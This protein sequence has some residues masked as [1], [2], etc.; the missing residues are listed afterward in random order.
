MPELPEVQTVLN[1]ITPHV[2]HQK[3]KRI[4]LHFPKLRWPIPQEITTIL[5]NEKILELSRRG[6][7]ILIHFTK[8]TLL[9]HLGMS[10]RLCVVDAATPLK[11]HDHVDIILSNNRCLRFTDPRRFG[12][13]LWT[14]DDINEHPLIKII[15]PEPLEDSFNGTYLWEKSRKKSVAVKTFI[16]NSKIVAG[17]GN[18]YA[19]EALFQAKIHPKKT[20]GKLTRE[21]CNRLSTS[22]K[23]VLKSAIKKGGTTL[24]DFVSADGNPGYFS[25]ELKVYGR[26]N[27][28]CVRCKTLLK[29]TRQ[30]NRSTVFC[31]RCQKL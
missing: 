4:D 5:K 18:I 10:G 1:G 26:G 25:I 11:K 9:I 13:V 21:E 17:V 27:E 16:M 30:A 12:A 24:K 15:G 29:T 2:L 19:A 3:I 6:K 7:Y 28:P 22:I 23:S 8:G 14:K 20:T 31:P